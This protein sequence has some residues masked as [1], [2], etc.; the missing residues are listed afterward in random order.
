MLIWYNFLKTSKIEASAPSKNN[1]QYISISHCFIEQVFDWG[2]QKPKSNKCF[3][4]FPI[5]DYS[6]HSLNF[7]T[8]KISNKIKQNPNF[9][10]SNSLSYPISSKPTKIK[11]FTP[12]TTQKLK[13]HFAKNPPTI[14]KTSLFISTF[15]D[16]HF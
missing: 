8:L 14:P 2:W 1:G 10:I 9:H 11:H 3:S 6:T 13:S 4:I 5:A 15:T 7:K 12:L 16:N